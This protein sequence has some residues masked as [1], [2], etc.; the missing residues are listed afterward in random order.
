MQLK[1]SMDLTPYDIP[2]I[3]SPFLAASETRRKINA[4]QFREHDLRKL[5]RLQPY[6]RVDLCELAVKLVA[7]G[8]AFLVHGPMDEGPL[9]P[10]VAWRSSPEQPN[11]GEW[12]PTGQLP[13]GL[14]YPLQDLNS[15]RLTPQDIKRGPFAPGSGS[16]TPRQHPET[17][18]SQPHQPRQASS[19]IASTASV[20]TTTIAGIKAAEDTESQEEKEPEVHVEVGI[21]T[22]GTLNNVFNSQQMQKTTEKQCSKALENGTASIEECEQLIALRADTSYSNAP[23]NIAKLWKVYPDGIQDEQDRRVY[24]YPVYAPGVGTQNGEEDLLIDAA[25]GLGQTGVIAQ[26]SKAFEELKRLLSM[27]IKNQKIKRLTIDLFG[28]SRGAAAARHAS[29]EIS[30]GRKGLLGRMF[31]EQQLSWPD[32]VH[33]RF[34]GIF[35][36]VAGIINVQSGDLFAHNEHNDPVKLYIDSRNVGR[37]LHITASDEKRKNFALNSI[38]NSDKTLPRNFKELVLPGAHSDIGGGYAEE[39]IEDVQISPRIPIPSSRHKWPKQT[40]EWDSLKTLKAEIAREEWI[41][42]YSLPLEQNIETHDGTATDEASLRID[43]DYRSHPA[44]DG[45]M[46]IMLRMIRNVRGGYSRIPL[47]LMHSEAKA[48]GV[49]LRDLSVHSSESELP[50]DLTSLLPKFESLLQDPSGEINLTDSELS[51]IRQRYTHYSAHYNDY[52]T[53]FVSVPAQISLFR[54]LR[55]N[56]PA[57]QRAIYPNRDQ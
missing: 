17:D 6:G 24:R 44:P 30:K 50:Q 52:Q 46:E 10:V 47:R 4:G 21:F 51:L 11:G 15:A 19:T 12:R 5:L 48:A 3:E 26:V 34:L 36:T 57:A 56:V 54:N 14:S 42:E 37:V 49:P 55:P 2:R 33:I 41:G 40:V 35:D 23:T 16:P 32:E 43:H 8:G 13:F 27:D 28:F 1:R 39:F 53:S 45:Q 31:K 25:T 38:R 18:E 7:S 9:S 29:H 20:M 22:D